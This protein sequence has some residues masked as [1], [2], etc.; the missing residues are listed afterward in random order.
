MWKGYVESKMEI[1]STEKV[2]A[3]IPFPIDALKLKNT[4]IV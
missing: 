4:V 2:Q 1:E 3:A